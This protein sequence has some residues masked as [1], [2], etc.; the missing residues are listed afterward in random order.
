MAILTEWSGLLLLHGCVCVELW[1]NQ[2]DNLKK[3]MLWQKGSD[4]NDRSSRRRV[5]C[6]Q[7]NTFSN[8]LIRTLRLVSSSSVKNDNTINNNRH[9][10]IKNVRRFALKQQNGKSTS[11]NR[12]FPDIPSG[13]LPH[14][15]P[16]VKIRHRVSIFSFLVSSLNHP[17][18]V[19]GAPDFSK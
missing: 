5:L 3:L 6:N 14:R 16:R 15:P 19:S 8:Q 9:I 10:V 2:V 13:A 1:D 18:V 4:G 11:G 7:F 17:F 12:S